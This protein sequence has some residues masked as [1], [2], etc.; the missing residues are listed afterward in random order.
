MHHSSERNSSRPV[1]PGRICR[2]VPLSLSPGDVP[3]AGTSFDPFP[4]VLGIRYRLISGDRVISIATGYVHNDHPLCVVWRPICVSILIDFISN[5][6]RFLS[7]TMNFPI[8]LVGNQLSPTQRPF[9]SA[10]VSHAILIKPP[11]QTSEKSY[12]LNGDRLNTLTD[13]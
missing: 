5:H 9:S 2:S 10:P 3:S 12:R 1:I 6:N 11:H 8:A 13:L 4:L 7:R